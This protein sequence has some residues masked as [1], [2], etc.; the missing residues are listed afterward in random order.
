MIQGRSLSPLFF[1]F[2]CVH[3]LCIHQEENTLYWAT[4]GLV[5]GVRNEL[6]DGVLPAVPDTWEMLDAKWKV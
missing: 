3:W 2:W 5:S 1:I 4:T 6:K